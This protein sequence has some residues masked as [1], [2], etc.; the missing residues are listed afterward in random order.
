MKT[1]TFFK[2]FKQLTFW[3][4]RNTTTTINCKSVAAAKL[5]ILT[6]NELNSYQQELEVK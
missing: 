5:V 1:A 3:D 4:S 6:R 2:K